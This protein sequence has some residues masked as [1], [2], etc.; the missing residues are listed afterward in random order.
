MP[1]TIP[2]DIKFALRT[3]RRSPGFIISAVL[4]LALGIGA[5]TSIFSIV[6][7]VLL[8]PLPFAEPDRLVQINETDQRFGT[9]P[10]AYLDL[11]EF[12]TDTSTFQEIVSY[13]NFARSLLDVANPERL[14]VVSSDR[15]LFRMLGV[16]PI[17][18]RTF[19]DDDPPDV[20]VLSA[21]FWKRRFAADPACIGR[22]IT[23]DHDIFTIIGVM[24]ERFQF[25]F[26]NSLTQVWIPWTIPA[27]FTSNRYYRVDSV[28]A[29]LQPGV[30]IDQGQR[31]LSVIA[32]R[33][34]SQYPNTNKG[35]RALM[36]PLAE[37]VTGRVRSSLLTLLGAVGLVLFIAC[38]NVA[39]LLLARSS[40]RSREFAVRAALGAN[41]SRLIRQLLTESV[42]LSMISGLLG[43]LI[44]HWSTRLIL[45]L[46]SGQ[47]PR[48][49]E[50]GLDWRVFSFLL[51]ASAA[52]GIAAG[53]LPAF[54][55]TRASLR[56]ALD[57]PR[58]PWLRDGLVIAEI[59]LSFVLLVSAGLVL[60][61]FLALQNTPAGLVS[62]NVLTL[63]MTIILKD[64]SAPGS[65]GRYLHTLAER[66]KTV[67]GVRAA[68]FIQY[69]PLQ[70][71]GWSAFFSIAGRPQPAGRPREAE[72]R[73]V[74]PDYFRTLGIPLR[75][76]RFFTEADT[77]SS[78]LVIVVNEALAR[79]YFGSD[80]PVGQRTDRGTIIGVVGDVRSSQLD[81]P[82]AP[83]IY[84]TFAQNTAATSDAGVS[85][86]VSALA[87]PE[88]LVRSVRDA[89]QQVNPLQVIFG[90]KT[91]DRVIAESFADVNLYLWLIGLF[92]LIALVL[93]MAGVYG[94]IS[95]VVSARTREFGIRLA[96]GAPETHLLRLVLGRGSG[97]AIIGIVLGVGGSLAAGR[98][99]SVLRGV[100]PPDSATLAI[101][102]L[103]L[104]LVA[105][106]A[107]LVPAKRAMQVDP[108]VAL[109]YE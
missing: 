51:A 101:V 20:A 12:R 107:C 25:P 61:A 49:W 42:L 58:V 60:Q 64:Y 62:E 7:G 23:L 10:V 108:N 104:A 68:G 76:G 66:I 80:D 27:A 99:L 13:G 103:L 43:L 94:V 88:T 100:K 97:L 4:M 5:N 92:A 54:T 9:G 95:Y 82:A 6:S 47:I 33:L 72:L 38:A 69:L 105:V 32:S 83:E 48:S 71:W 35:R 28:I 98:L 70:N 39:N 89:I 59:A 90:V 81:R 109:R 102:G 50:I 1:S 8:R 18:G 30:T 53:I 22:K 65:Y 14:A 75:R 84:Y 63:Q 3:A 19:R 57:Q 37:V 87:R 16:A 44:A 56:T 67:P 17:I 2:Q 29:R 36:T 26:R 45:N 77:S 74:S 73:Y 79:K 21:G 106:A 46:A 15:G 31:E 34:E 78:P 40:T 96:L 52:T 93:A 24:P 11:Q 91:M 85:L 86:V 41:R 55:V